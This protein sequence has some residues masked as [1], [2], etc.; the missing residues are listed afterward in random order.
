MEKTLNEIFRNRVKKYGDKLCVEKKL[1]GKR[2]TTTWNE[3]LG[4]STLTD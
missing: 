1:N 2:E 4:Y 3:C